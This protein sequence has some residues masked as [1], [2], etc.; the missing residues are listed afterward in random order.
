MMMMMMMMI[1]TIKCTPV[2]NNA[3]KINGMEW[4]VNN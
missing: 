2:K 3:E 4:N 1:M